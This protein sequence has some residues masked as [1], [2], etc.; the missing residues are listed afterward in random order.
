MFQ[1]YRKTKQKIC[2]TVPRLKPLL[3]SIGATMN[4]NFLK[5]VLVVREVYLL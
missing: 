1:K 2:H 3:S 4:L 5:V